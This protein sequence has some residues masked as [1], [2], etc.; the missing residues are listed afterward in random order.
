MPTGSSL[1]ERAIIARSR[2]YGVPEHDRCGDEIEPAG[3]VALVLK[4]AI[5]D[6]AQP[7]KEHR[8]GQRIACFTLIESSMNTPTQF[9]VLEPVEDE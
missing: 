4:A 3:T 5:P 6:F 8:S 7:V 9:D 1:C 2:Y